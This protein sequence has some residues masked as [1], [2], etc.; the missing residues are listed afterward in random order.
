MAQK[1]DDGAVEGIRVLPGREMAAVRQ[2][3]QLGAGNGSRDVD[4]MLR[5]NSSPAAM[6]DF[7]NLGGRTIQN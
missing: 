7:N 5:V 1:G 2:D 3:L 4:E 6:S